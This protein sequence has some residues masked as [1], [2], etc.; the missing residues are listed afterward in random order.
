MFAAKGSEDGEVR[1]VDGQAPLSASVWTCDL[2]GRQNGGGSCFDIFSKDSIRTAE[3]DMLTVHGRR[4]IL[5]APG[6]KRS[7]P[8]TGINS[9]I[10]PGTWSAARRKWRVCEHRSLQSVSALLCCSSSNQAMMRTTC[11]VECGSVRGEGLRGQ[12]V[13]RG[14]RE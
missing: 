7:T 1:P 8:L 9:L 10:R 13:E 12:A 14:Q 11:V 5:Q 2:S 6:M 3:M 4:F